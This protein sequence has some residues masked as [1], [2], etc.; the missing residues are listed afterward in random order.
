MSAVTRIYRVEY[1]GE[2]RHVIERDGGVWLLEGDVFGTYRAGEKVA[3]VA[4]SGAVPAGLRLLAPVLPSKVVGIGLNYRDHAA[5]TNTPIPAEPIVF[6][7]PSTSV[8]G[9]GEPIRIPPG[10][11]R[12]DY[13][14]ELGV[15]ISRR[16][17]RVTRERAHEH[18]LGLTCVVDVTAREMQRR[19]V[20]WSH[21]KG[22]DTFAPVGP[23]VAVGLS[24]EL[25][26][27]GWLNDERR[28][29]SNTRELIFTIDDLVA[30]IS[31]IMTLLPGDVIAT[32][33]PSGIGEIKPGDRFK[34]R[35]DG[36][37]ELG[38]PV[39]GL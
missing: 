37:G 19:G 20:Q 10:V 12:V 4:T 23:C 5:E 7:K 22:Y 35:I 31:S 25:P 34:V 33:T 26:I 16:A 17:R 18:V 11:G 29:V 27:E 13:E 9:P 21:C 15:V 24:P 8:I 3:E 6:V 1:R 30:Y 2:P 39:E 36:I 28:Q 14:A 32:G 38:N